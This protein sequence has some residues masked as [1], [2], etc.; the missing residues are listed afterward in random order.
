MAIS[1][2]D[3]FHVKHLTQTFHK[4]HIIHAEFIGMNLHYSHNK[5]LNKCYPYQLYSKTYTSKR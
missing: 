5:T 3:D 2:S 4:N 1:A